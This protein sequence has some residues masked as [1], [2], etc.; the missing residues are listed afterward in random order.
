M[1]GGGVDLLHDPS[2]LVAADG[3]RLLPAA[4]TA[5]AQVRAVHAAL[6]D[7]PELDTPR[8]L[9]IAGTRVTAEADLLRAAIGARATAPVVAVQELPSWVGALDLV[10]VLAGQVHDPIAG[11]AAEQAARRGATVIVRAAAGTPSPGAHAIMLPPQVAVTEA[12]AAPARLA[13]LI[14]VAHRCGLL[15]TTP[16]LLDWADTLDATSL[17]CHPSAE[18]FVNPAV[19]LAEYLYDGAPLLVGGDPMG[20]AIAALAGQLLTDLAGVAA[21]VLPAGAAAQSP[22]VLRRAAVSR[23]LFA[24]PFADPAEGPPWAVPVIITLGTDPAAGALAAALPSAPVVAPDRN[25]ASDRRPDHQYRSDLERIPGAGPERPGRERVAPERTGQDASRPMDAASA[26]AEL[27][28]RLTFAAVYLGLAAGQLPPLDAP[29]GLGPAGTALGAVR[30]EE[31]GA[32]A[33][34]RDLDAGD[35]D[36]RL[37]DDFLSSIGGRNP[38]DPNPTDPSGI[39]PAG[40]DPNN[41]EESGAAGPT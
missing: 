20:D 14:G 19:T 2:G 22:A 6:A 40:A 15:R 11:I 30:A 17:A 35:D 16:D 12:L 36:E 32:F 13:L 29:D 8:A 5:G 4:A 39:D 21:A 10:V 31:R 41:G 24:D 26:A 38:A 1:T 28:L 37:D 23:D 9:V 34:I 27:V 33:P 25:E 7:L 3:A 18:E